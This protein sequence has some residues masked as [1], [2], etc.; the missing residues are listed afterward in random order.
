M[1]AFDK[2]VSRNEVKND[3]DTEDVINIGRRRPSSMLKSLT[4]KQKTSAPLTQL[5]LLKDFPFYWSHNII[6]VFPSTYINQ[7]WKTDNVDCD[8]GGANYN[9]YIIYWLEIGCNFLQQEE[10][11]FFNA[12]YT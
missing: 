9:S 12:Q 4:S 10:T 8:N 3:N 2:A 1:Q 6:N 11:H 7:L 5:H